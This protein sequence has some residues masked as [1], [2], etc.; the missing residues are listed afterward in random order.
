M[1]K[2]KAARQINSTDASREVQIALMPIANAC[3]S[4]ARVRF[5]GDDMEKHLGQLTA[6]IVT[7]IHQIKKGDLTQLEELLYTQAL[8]LDATFHKFLAQAAAGNNQASLMT[9]Q[10]ELISGLAALAL[11]AQDQSRKTLVA[12]AELKNPKRSTTFIKNYVDKQLNQVTSPQPKKL[13]EDSR[14]ALDIASQRK[15][16]PDDTA[17]ETLV[18]VHRSGNSGGSSH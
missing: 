16:T 3:L 9:H 11:K 10:F 14:A 8:T 17:M 1:P 4:V 2:K 18:E 13:Q 15:T 7:Q 5:P 6:E 12:L